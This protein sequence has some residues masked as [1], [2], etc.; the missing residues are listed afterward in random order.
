LRSALSFS[1]LERRSSSARFL[2]LAA[3]AARLDAGGSSDVAPLLTS[4]RLR[5]VLLLKERPSS[6]TASGTSRAVRS[7]TKL[8]VPFARDQ[9]S[10]GGLSVTIG[11]HEWESKLV[12]HCGDSGCSKTDINTLKLLAELPSLDPF[13]VRE[14]LRAASLPYHEGSFQLSNA[15]TIR[16]QGFVRD[17]IKKLIDLAYGS[18]ASTDRL[19]EKLVDALLSSADDERLE[20]LRK[21][22]QLNPDHYR[23]GVFAWIG[24]LYYKWTLNESWVALKK[25][26]ENLAMVGP[27]GKVEATVLKEMNSAK[28]CVRES[29]KRHVVEVKRYLSEYDRLFETI[30][31]GGN[32]TLFRDFLLA[33]PSMFLALGERSG[34]LGEFVHV[35]GD[36]GAERGPEPSNAAALLQLLQHTQAELA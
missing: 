26:L 32:A 11:E 2:N 25:S 27:A 16:M 23:E 19:T 35:W 20:P 10:L 8:V 15:D 17:E 30:T 9:L 31:S 36:S 34:L 24:F 28:L 13:L 18:D 14:T 3:L 7:T 6:F 21:T 33:A 1:D 5:G 4:A 22:L 29:I 12:L